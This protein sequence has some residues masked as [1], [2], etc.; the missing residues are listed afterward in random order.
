MLMATAPVPRAR[1][2]PQPSAAR[3]SG[4]PADARLER[5]F[6]KLCTPSQCEPKGPVAAREPPGVKKLCS[7]EAWLQSGAVPRLRWPQVLI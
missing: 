5:S 4:R 6:C 7:S 1:A 2:A 3:V